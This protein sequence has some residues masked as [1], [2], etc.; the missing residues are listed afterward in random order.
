MSAVL[1]IKGICRYVL[2]LV[3]IANFCVAAMAQTAQDARQAKIARANRDVAEA[4]ALEQ[5][6]GIENTTAAVNKLIPAVAVF[7]EFGEKELQMTGLAMLGNFQ[8]TINQRDNGTASLTKAV[9]LARDLNKP[10][11]QIILLSQLGEIYFANGKTGTNDKERAKAFIEDAVAV[12]EKLDPKPDPIS[13]DAYELL[14]RIWMSLYNPTNARSAFI[15]AFLLKKDKPAEESIPAIIVFAKHMMDMGFP[16]LAVAPLED[17]R[18]KALAAKLPELE[19][20][21]TWAIGDLMAGKFRDLPTAKR[22]LERTEQLVAANPDEALK[23]K[24][25]MSWGKYYF[26][27]FDLQRSAEYFTKALDPKARATPEGLK[28]EVLL[29]FG[30]LNYSIGSL[31]AASQLLT[32]AARLNAAENRKLMEMESLRYLARCQD[33]MGKLYD[34]LDTMAKALS[35]RGESGQ[36][37]YSS[38]SVAVLIDHADLFIELAEKTQ[39]ASAPV[40]VRLGRARA[41]LEMALRNAQRERMQDLQSLAS[42]RLAYVY[43]LLGDNAKATGLLN[44]A[45]VTTRSAGLPV[46]EASAMTGL[47]DLSIKMGNSGAA[48]FYGKSAVNVF[49]QLRKRISVLAPEIR[50]SYLKTIEGTYR[51]LASLL[52]EQGRIGEAEQVLTLLKEEELM[53]FVRRDDS[54]AK[55]MLQTLSLTEDERS[56]ITRYDTIADQITALG[57]EFDALEQERRNFAVGAFPKQQRYDQVKQQLADA[58][59]AFQKFLEGL[60]LTFG[61]NNSSV[62]QV[63]SGLKKLL[64]DPKNEHVAIVSTIVG[65]DALNIIVTTRRAQ[66]AHTVKIAAKDISE[67][68]VKFRSALTSPQ[69]D[70][71]PSGQKLYDLIVKPIEGDLAGIKA[72][73]ILWSFDG[74]LRYLPPAALWD[75]TNGYLAERFANVMINLA[76]RDGLNAPR[77][78]GQLSALGVGVSKPTEGFS[79]LTAVP[80]ELDCIVSDKTAGI[81]S[82]KPQCTNGVLTGR[83]LLDEKFTLANFEGE[84][85]RYPIVHIA[86]HFKLTPG[87]NK[88]SFLLLGGGDDR[89]FTVEKLQNEQQMTDVDLI[90]L[91]ACNTATPG[92]TKANGLE[93]EGFGSIA[94]KEGAKAVMAT[95]WS[96]A[97]TST[98]DFM[99]EFY[100]LYGR[101]GLS[102]ADAMRKAQLKLMYGKYSS[103]QAQKHRADD[104]L[105]TNDDSLP[106]FTPDPNAPFAH[107]FYWS[108]FV[109]TGNWQ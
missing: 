50:A 62:V 2:A 93:I 12:I 17:A 38:E 6:G 92:G 42:Q 67:L 26:A 99:V 81:L 46:Q 82:T 15:K 90:V 98:K 3:L 95:L 64:A 77:T 59:T 29:H 4:A 89:K 70:P 79:A 10:S 65:D 68:V 85:G 83:K 32:E 34:A 24:L 49:Q 19:A 31:E 52:I 63:D 103:D 87:D 23:A 94:Q 25:M 14:G 71:R 107:P 108:P 1:N 96:V 16:K 101:E 91:S 30:I 102:K 5:K 69:Y 40:D 21:S 33:A 53:E 51:K 80:D 72:N 57:K 11:M 76:S 100:R 56:A 13:Y 47:M 74:V 35:A 55:S 88:N 106:K 36:G 105:T 18:K 109:L 27:T 58:S 9:E 22:Y 41:E 48:V 7:A 75:K 39:S 104:F 78:P 73:T 37:Y 84:L 44:D 86:S 54:V 66:R 8:L 20:L 28:G 43:S 97:D 60:K 61:Q 45:L